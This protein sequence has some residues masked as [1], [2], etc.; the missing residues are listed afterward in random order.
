MYQN[1]KYSGRICIY[2]VQPSHGKR[3]QKVFLEASQAPTI[4]SLG[5]CSCIGAEPTVY[6][7]TSD[8][9]VHV[10]TLKVMQDF[11]HQQY[12]HDGHGLI[13][14]KNG[15]AQKFKSQQ[16]LHKPMHSQYKPAETSTEKLDT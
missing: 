11:Y 3:P 1:Y 13:M 7:K 5:D 6:T 10:Y 15:A 2:W 14:S 9:I 16:R 4:A 12:Q 8:S